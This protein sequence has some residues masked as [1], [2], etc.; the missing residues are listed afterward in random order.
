[1]PK[2]TNVVLLVIATNVLS[3]TILSSLHFQSLPDLSHFT[4]SSVLQLKMP[5]P[6][7]NQLS[8]PPPLVTAGQIL[9][10]GRMIQSVIENNKHSLETTL[11]PASSQD[12]LD[13]TFQSR[14]QNMEAVCAEKKRHPTQ[15]F[16]IDPAK[17]F[18]LQ[19][20]GIVWCPVFKAGSSTWLSTILELSSKSKV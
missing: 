4:M 18:V 15:P 13:A 14:K 2:C 17:L 10:T 16:V 20:R 9:Q 8:N 1:M 7:P 12:D 19:D 6:Q 5:V 11:M 3:L